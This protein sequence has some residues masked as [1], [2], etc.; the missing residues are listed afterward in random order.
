MVFQASN[1]KRKLKIELEKVEEENNN[2][3][4]EVKELED[5]LAECET[6]KETIKNNRD[7][8]FSGMAAI[9]LNGI[10]QT[11]MGKKIISGLGGLGSTEKSDSKLT[12][13]QETF[14]ELLKLI[15]NKVP[16][17]KIEVFQEIINGMIEN[18]QTIFFLRKMLK[19]YLNTKKKPE[20]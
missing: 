7:L 6:E 16:Q 5:A 15:H 1:K 12:E 9:A 10:A 17:D 14:L 4:L 18:P 8:N 11:E 19:N 13:E 20:S 2:L 3:K